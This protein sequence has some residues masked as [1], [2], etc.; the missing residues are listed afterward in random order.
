MNENKNSK[1]LSDFQWTLTQKK[2]VIQKMKKEVNYSFEWLIFGF[3]LKNFLTHFFLQILTHL[4]KSQRILM[5]CFG[6]FI[7][8]YFITIQFS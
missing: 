4:K 2:M 6:N 8:K 3:M 1:F 5:N 7:I